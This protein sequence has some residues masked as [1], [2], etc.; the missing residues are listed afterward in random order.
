MESPTYRTTWARGVVLEV[1]SVE[2]SAE[3]TVAVYSRSF[4]MTVAL[5]YESESVANH[6][7]TYSQ[8][9][10]VPDCIRCKSDVSQL[11]ND[12]PRLRRA[13]ATFVSPT[14]GL[15]IRG[16]CPRSAG[17]RELTPSLGTPYASAL[18]C[19]AEGEAA[20]AS[21]RFLIAEIR[22]GASGTHPARAAR[23]RAARESALPQL[24]AAE[25]RVLQLHMRCPAA[26]A[27][28]ARRAFQRDV[29]RAP[30]RRGCCRAETARRRAARGRKAYFSV[31]HPAESSDL[32][33]VTTDGSSRLCTLCATD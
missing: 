18:R 14:A 10:A 13:C 4:G 9:D 17:V 21:G 26:C 11:D 1:S 8:H 32:T 30:R 28:A 31:F 6:A 5:E 29:R 22:V 19:S 16:S 3:S 33:R 15:S 7:R 27:H 20:R 2:A 12:K 25:N 24:A 23:R